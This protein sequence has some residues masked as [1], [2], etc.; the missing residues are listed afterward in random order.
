[1]QD[2]P[3]WLP[4]A[5]Q[6][7]LL[8]MLVP[9]TWLNQDPSFQPQWKLPVGW[10]PPGCAGDSLRPPAEQLDPRLRDGIHHVSDLQVRQLPLCVWSG[11]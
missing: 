10:E 9:A 1:M 5:Q 8:N 11:A 3:S 4:D 6:Q 2:L 7:Q